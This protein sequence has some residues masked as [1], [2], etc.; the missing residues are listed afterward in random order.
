MTQDAFDAFATHFGDLHRLNAMKNG[1]IVVP[2]FSGIRTFV[3]V[4]SSLSALKLIHVL[5]QVSTIVQC[6]YAYRIRILSGS[7]ALASGIALVN[8]TIVIPHN[9]PDLL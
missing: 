5:P 9:F 2:L 4:E 3:P 7:W 8:R 6:Y 1:W